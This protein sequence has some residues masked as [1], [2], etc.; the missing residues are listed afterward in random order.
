[1]DNYVITIA[2]GFGSGG[3]TIGKMLSESLGIPY[4]DK[5]LIKLASEES[6]IN[7]ALFGKSDEKVKGGL[8]SKTKV[9]SGE[10]AAPDS[11]DFVS[12]EN[13]FSYQAKIIKSLADK[14]SC[15]I[16]GRCADFILKDRENV[17]KTFIWADKETCIKNAKAVCGL[18]EKEAEK[19]I[20]RIDKE[21][22]AYYK[23]HTGSN[24]DNVRNYD[25]CLDTSRLSFEKCVEIIKTYI[26]I[27]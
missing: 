1:M 12:E 23:A 20:E 6:G 5:D 8:F 21:R 15:I 13:L 24:W 17:I 16:V 3:K 2:R 11:A 22:S 19:Q 7:E 4:Y 18:D 14:G 25:L 10:I 9:Y 27:L 26:E